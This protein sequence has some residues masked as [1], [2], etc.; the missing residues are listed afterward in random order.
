MKPNSNDTDR[1]LRELVDR[2]RTDRPAPLDTAA[3]LRALR[4]A[5]AP[6]M[7]PA[8]WEDFAALFSTRLSLGAC[9]AGAAASLLVVGWLAWDVW[10]NVLPWA[11]MVT[12]P[13]LFS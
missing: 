8:W 4:P 6:A 12:E 7:A 13:A 1:A 5:S 3:L 11:E 10:Q 2:A 9:S